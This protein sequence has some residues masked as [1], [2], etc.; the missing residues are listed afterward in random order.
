MLYVMKI[1][2]KKKSVF[3]FP[4]IEFLCLFKIFSNCAHFL[5]NPAHSS[6]PE[7]IV[8]QARMKDDPE[9]IDDRL[10]W[11]VCSTHWQCNYLARDDGSQWLILTSVPT[12]PYIATTTKHEIGMHTS[13]IW[14][15]VSIRQPVNK[16]GF[17][18]GRPGLIA[19]IS[20]AYF[21]MR[22]RPWL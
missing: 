6:R 8:T 7:S 17:I 19:Y 22:H 15:F 11:M 18:P 3:S 20:R 4:L 1:F 2:G 21:Y 13:E 5:P 14:L 10:K 12:D 9:N 16:L